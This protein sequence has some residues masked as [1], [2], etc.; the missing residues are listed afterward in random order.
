MFL[1][2]KDGTTC[3]SERAVLWIPC[4]KLCNDVQQE[5]AKPSPDLAYELF[6][7]GLLH[8]IRYG[9]Q[10][11]QWAT[12]GFMVGLLNLLL[13]NHFDVFITSDH[14][15]IEARGCGQV[16]EGTRHF[17]VHNTHVCIER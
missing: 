9:I 10:V 11:R 5:G 4:R 17:Q 1:G 15:N 6:C 3:Y 8:N 7:Y 16:S 12:Q 2:I 13:Q 14:G